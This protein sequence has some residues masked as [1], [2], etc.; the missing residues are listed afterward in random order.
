M[1]RNSD[2][3]F[4]EQ[5]FSNI[6][7]SPNF[8]VDID[9]TIFGASYHQYWVSA[10]FKVGSGLIY[11]EMTRNLSKSDSR[12]GIQFTSLFIEFVVWETQ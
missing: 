7:G 10:T 9:P 12:S 4:V 8:L 11:L 6:N 3:K 5:N 2:L 1:V